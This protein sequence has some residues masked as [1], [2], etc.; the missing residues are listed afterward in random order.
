MWA[1]GLAGAMMVVMGA[2]RTARAADDPL[3]VVV[4]APP[5]LSVDAADVRRR[6]AI[7]LGQPVISPSDPA[8]PRTSQVMIVA[9]DQ[10]DIR[11]TMRDG[12]SSRISRTIPDLPEHAARL[13][14]V[15]WLAG[16][17]ARDQ[18]GPLLPNLAL[19]PTPKPAAAPVTTAATP[20]TATPTA[21]PP[22]LA[23]PPA[24]AVPPVRPEPASTTDAAIAVQVD[25]SDASVGPRWA[26]TASGGATFTTGCLWIGSPT[27]LTCPAGTGGGIAS[28]FSYGSVFQL[29]VVHKIRDEGMMI[30]AALE[31]GPDPHLVGLAGLIGT[32]RPWGHWYLEAT[33]G[34]G[35]E[36]ER[37]RVAI[38]QTTVTSS[39]TG[40]N[41][42]TTVGD[43]VQPALYVRATGSIGIPIN[44]SFDL[45]ASLN[46]HLASSGLATDFIGAT[47]GLRLKLP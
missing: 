21:P 35:I 18:V 5:Q 17:M 12:A 15:A 44:R 10:H 23:E 1:A 43:Q 11:L 14:A 4:E 32:R 29:E 41:S 39:Q 13:R 3:L 38:S 36:A 46:A 25:D 27:T 30:G 37:L 2:A 19:A 45:L 34:A 9:L 33:L 6:I 28:S 22:T 47:A 7:E 42:E 26:I 31:T 24:I 20:T 16:N 8:A 40:L